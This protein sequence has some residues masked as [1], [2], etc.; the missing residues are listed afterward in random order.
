MIFN[1]TLIFHST[2]ISFKPVFLPY[3]IN[4]TEP[5]RYHICKHKDIELLPSTQVAPTSSKSL[6]ASYFKSEP[7]EIHLQR[8]NYPNKIRNKTGSARYSQAALAI[9]DDEIIQSFPPSMLPILPYQASHC[10]TFTYPSSISN[11]KSSPRA[12]WKVL[13]VPLPW[14]RTAAYQSKKMLIVPL[15]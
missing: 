9:R 4:T 13:I 11:K 12:I 5:Y 2:S 10:S 1:P 14:Q 7:T 6:L 3:N 15:P 8:I